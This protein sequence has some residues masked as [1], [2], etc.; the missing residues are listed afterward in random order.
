[1]RI[2]PVLAA[3]LALAACAGPRLAGSPEPDRLGARRQLAQAVK[4]GPVPLT[5][6]GNPSPLDSDGVPPLGA[7]GVTGLIAAFPGAP[8][9]TTV[10]HLVLWFAP[11]PE[12][13][14]QAA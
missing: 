11:P 13:D 14:A 5:T 3:T 9:T 4:A 10:P 2:P 12:A 1:M 8:A 6:V 7:R